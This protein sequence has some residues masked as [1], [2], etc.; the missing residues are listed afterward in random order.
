[1]DLLLDVVATSCIPHSI[2]IDM[3]GD[4]NSLGDVL[5]RKWHVYDMHWLDQIQIE[6]Y[7]ITGAPFGG[8]IALIRND[9][10]VSTQLAQATSEKSKLKIFTSAGEL[11]AE[12]CWTGLVN[13]TYPID[14]YYCID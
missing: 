8:P 14:N 12:V 13:I 9:R 1:M 4:W 7:H 2:C 5:Y 6:D 10:K 3:Q 11:I